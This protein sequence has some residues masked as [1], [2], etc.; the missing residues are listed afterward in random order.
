[1][2]LFA[3]RARLL[4]ERLQVV[5]SRVREIHALMLVDRDG[6]TLVSTL[7]AR[8]LEDGLA[9]FAGAAL[10]QMDRASSDFEMGPV[11]LLHLA[12]RDRQLFLTPVTREVGL[13]AVVE[14]GADAASVSLYLLAV[15]REILEIAYV[16]MESEG[17]AS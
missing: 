13:V 9:A 11:H 15:A 14:A 17:A 7:H 16:T 8:G 6:L 2:K 3:S 10:A 1:M 5:T 4:A 12:G